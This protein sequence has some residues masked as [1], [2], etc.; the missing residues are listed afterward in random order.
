MSQTMGWLLI[1]HSLPRIPAAVAG[2]LLLLQPSLFF[3]WDVR[4]C[5]RVTSAAAWR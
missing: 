3:V 4:F 2:L 1:T 5:D